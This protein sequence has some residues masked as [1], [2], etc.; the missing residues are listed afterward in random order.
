MVTNL[1]NLYQKNWAKYIEDRFDKD[2]KVLRCKVDL[3]KLPDQPGS[4]MLRKFYFYKNCLWSL[5][6]ITNYS[7]TTDD[8]TECEFVQVRD[9]K[10]YI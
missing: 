9:T 4:E 8:L 2:T 1:E 3:S 5:N 7:V 6:K 10:N